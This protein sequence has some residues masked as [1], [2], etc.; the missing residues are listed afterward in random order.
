MRKITMLFAT[1][2]ALI[3]LFPS[4]YAQNMQGDANGYVQKM[5]KGEVNWQTGLVKAT[6]I[7][8]PPENAANMAQA[9]AMALRAATVVARRNLLE[10]IKGVRINSSTKVKNYMVQN[11]VI[12]TKVQGFLQNSQVLN[13][14]Y[15]SDGS[16]QVEVGVSLRG[17][18]ADVL[19][20]EKIKF[21]KKAPK[22]TS[23]EP[24][25]IEVSKEAKPAEQAPEKEK[26]V[27]EQEKKQ[28]DV[29]MEAKGPVYTGLVVDARGINARPAM[30]PKIV[31][32]N[33]SEVY[34]SAMVS[35]EYAI[36]Q[37]MAGYAKVMD[38]AKQNSRVA[39]NPYVVQAISSE[40]K[41]NTDLVVSSSE[42]NK[43]RKLSDNLNFLE[44]CRVMIVL[45]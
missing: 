25:P 42:A 36:Q 23:Y 9:R 33:G 30:S 43:L 3:F 29:S 44:K 45:K 32:E 18:F 10:V 7:G 22:P 1:F 14:E 38:K 41:T 35:R 34:G 27:Q 11:D 8:A 24:Q 5:T 19:M 37:G 26:T 16:V 17:G 13:T 6:G 28:K 39:E 31:D 15:M 20:P 12:V 2:V 40:G 4:A 21:N